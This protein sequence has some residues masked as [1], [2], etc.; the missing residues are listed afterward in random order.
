MEEQEIKAER[1]LYEDMLEQVKILPS[2]KQLYVV[3]YTSEDGR[4]FLHFWNY[5]GE[6]WNVYLEQ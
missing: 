5:G 1:N 2:N 6:S 4:L 3:K